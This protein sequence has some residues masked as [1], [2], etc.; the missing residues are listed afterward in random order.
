MHTWK[1]M[2]LLNYM[3]NSKPQ[4]ILANTTK[5]HKHGYCNTLNTSCVEPTNVVA[6]KFARQRKVVNTISTIKNRLCYEQEQNEHACT[7]VLCDATITQSN[8]Y[9]IVHVNVTS[10][11]TAKR[12]GGEG[13]VLKAAT[14]VNLCD[15]S[16]R[17]N[18][19]P[20]RQYRRTV[21]SVA[22]THTL[23][24]VRAYYY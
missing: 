12:V 13:E 24:S 19:K 18:I 3:G 21:K 22:H 11:K 15:P 1:I 4:Y 14:S 17:V 10:V 23:T 8:C 16:N 2:Q 9:V 7:H 20:H 6:R 5:Q